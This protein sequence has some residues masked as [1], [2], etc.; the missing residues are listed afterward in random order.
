MSVEEAIPMKILTFN[1]ITTNRMT[2]PSMV[3]QTVI[4][5]A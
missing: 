5:F 4:R 1:T 3:V 2:P